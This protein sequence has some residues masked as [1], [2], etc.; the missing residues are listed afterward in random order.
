[1]VSKVRLRA[2]GRGRVNSRHHT[3]S[4]DPVRGALLDIRDLVVRYDS[5]QVLHG[6]T[7]HVNDGEIVGLL[8]SNGAGKSTLL[9]TVSGL[10]RPAAGDIEFLG[11]DITRL[12]PSKILSAG[13]SH[14]AEGRRV[15]QTQTTSANLE[16]G[17][18]T[19]RDGKAAIAADLEKILALFPILSQKSQN[20]AATLSGGEQQ[21]LAIG[22]AMMSAPRLLMLDEPSAGLAP[23][24]VRLLVDRL[25][26]LKASGLTVIIVEQVVPLAMELCDRLY[27]VRN[28]RMIID[29]ARP[30]DLD[31]ATVKAAYV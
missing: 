1:M 11:S 15:F 22:Q 17:A 27:F 20:L 9:N 16:L 7:M 8:G 26:E 14:V 5:A 4:A 10:L 24:A 21:M 13:I 3:I 23:I 31:F 29:G 6:V 18:Y 25:R 2:I 12:S 28:G 19:R 30:S